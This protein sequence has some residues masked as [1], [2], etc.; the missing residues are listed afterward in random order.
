MDEIAFV[1]E[2]D[3][4]VQHAAE[5]NETVQRPARVITSI[6]KTGAIVVAVDHETR[7]IDLI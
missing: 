3:L 1:T 7:E 2:K 4:I 6:V 5:R